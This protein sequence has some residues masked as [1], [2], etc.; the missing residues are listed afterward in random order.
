MKRPQALL[1]AALLAAAL[2]AG[3]ADVPRAPQA[4]R[5]AAALDA[6]RTSD[7]DEIRRRFGGLENMAGQQ[8][9]S[10][11]NNPVILRE[12][13]WAVPGAQLQARGM[14]CYERTGKCDTVTYTVEY[15]AGQRRL[16]FVNSDELVYQTGVVNADGSLT[17]TRG[18]AISRASFDYDS[19]EMDWG[20]AGRWSEIGRQDYVKLTS[21]WEESDSQ[22]RREERLARRR[23][24]EETARNVNRAIQAFGQAYRETAQSHAQQQADRS[25]SLRAA[26]QMAQARQEAAARQ[27]AAAESA[28]RARAEAASRQFSRPTSTQLAPAPLTPLPGGS[29]ARTTP[30]PRTA[31]L[32][33]SSSAR[34][35]GP[36]VRPPAP[37]QIPTGVNVVIANPPPSA[38]PAAGN[39]AGAGMLRRMRPECVRPGTLCEFPYLDDEPARKPR[40]AQGPATGPDGGTSGTGGGTTP[41][42]G[43]PRPGG[44]TAGPAGGG[45]GDT[46]RGGDGQKR[47]DPRDIGKA[48]TREDPQRCITAAIEADPFIGSRPKCSAFAVYNRCDAP[49]DIKTCVWLTERSRWS[50]EQRS[51]KPNDRKLHESCNPV[52]GRHVDVRYSDDSRTRLRDPDPLR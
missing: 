19:G 15:D 37:P 34:T 33:P 21:T 2:V 40:V 1:A 12:W 48:S 31:Q 32:A 20:D 16:L 11:G 44:G 26:Q 4:Q 24:S 51:V 28:A 39:P 18:S 3:C 7:P 17:I 30:D 5:S 47:T 42:S 14:N 8:Y 45:S 36:A 49:V 10:S 41:G 27:Q 50:C 29:P 13:R 25:A 9:M 38:P 46:D 23:E 43:T 22:V 52:S 6:L 35:P